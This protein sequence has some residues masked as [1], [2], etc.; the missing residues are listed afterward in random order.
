[1]ITCTWE[2]SHPVLSQNL[3]FLRNMVV[4]EGQFL[5][6]TAM[7]RTLAWR[8]MKLWMKSA[9]RTLNNYQWRVVANAMDFCT[10]PIFSKLALQEVCRWKS[11]TA[12][13]KTVLMTNVQVGEELS[14]ILPGQCLPAVREG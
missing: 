7:G 13:E 4:D 5:E 8:V 1:M 6:V 10:L 2:E 11:Y 12:P 3:A 9:G 14:T